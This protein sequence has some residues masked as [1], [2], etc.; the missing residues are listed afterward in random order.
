MALPNIYLPETTQ[1]LHARIDALSSQTQALWGKMKVAQMLSHCQ[2]AYQQILGENT[3]KPGPFMGWML[4]TFFKTSM[5]NEVPYKPNLPTGPTFIR[6]GQDFNFEEE[7]QKLKNYIQ[8]IQEMG[9]DRLASIPSLSLKKLTA[10]EWNNF[11]FKHIDHHLKQF[12]V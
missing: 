1:Q 2:V 8:R 12:G 7:Q 6:V 4:R 10:S 3:D 11:L 9:P 5:V